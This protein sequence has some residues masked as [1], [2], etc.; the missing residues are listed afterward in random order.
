[1]KVGGLEGPD[2]NV[3]VWRGVLTYLCIGLLAAARKVRYSARDGSDGRNMGSHCE[4]DPRALRQMCHTLS[5]C[6]P[7]R[8]SRGSKVPRHGLVDSVLQNTRLRDDLIR[9][10]RATGARNS[11]LGVWEVS[12]K[13][14]NL[15]RI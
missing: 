13:R 4:F 7:R 10:T 1:M 12:A 11:A 8:R 9:S 5:T 6:R 2:C 3:W 15:P 14:P